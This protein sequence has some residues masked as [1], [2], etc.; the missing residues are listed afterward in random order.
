[1]IPRFLTEG[2]WAAAIST[3]L[4]VWA[5]YAQQQYRIAA[6][7]PAWA[8]AWAGVA[9]TVFAAALTVRRWVQRRLA[10]SHEALVA[11]DRT[12]IGAHWLIRLYALW[13]LVLLANATLDSSEPDVKR[14]TVAR[15]TRGEA[16]FNQLVPLAWADLAFDSGEQRRALLTDDE[17]EALW[18]GQPVEVTL[19]AGALG[20]QRI[21]V[22]ARNEEAIHR[23]VLAVSPDA[24]ASWAGLL[25]IYA[26]RQS[27]PEVMETAKAYLRTSGDVDPVSVVAA[28]RFQRRD[29]RRA[30]ELYRLVFER[31]KSFNGYLYLGWTL[32]N[33]GQ[34]DEG[35]PLLRKAVE[36]NSETF[37]GYYH[38]AYACKYAGRK[39]EAAAAFQEVLKRRPDFPEIEQELRS[40]GQ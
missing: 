1:M 35:L 4:C 3:A 5:L 38:L 11:L 30:A 10:P 20:L 32:A 24:A 12:A 14:A 39:T 16:Y 36:L 15:L 26:K 18:G 6:G 25:R 40:L 19:R 37:W 21:E 7:T 17:A 34:F 33:L 22:I 13:S 2:R 29:Y 9:L 31:D 27:W 28:E 23:A 8:I